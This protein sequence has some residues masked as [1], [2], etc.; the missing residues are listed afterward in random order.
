MYLSQGTVTPDVPLSGPGDQ[1]GWDP[2]S[3]GR[4]FG[5]GVAQV[6]RNFWTVP[7]MTTARADQAIK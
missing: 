6:Q 4:V 3:I 2:W 5:Q 7:T 1:E